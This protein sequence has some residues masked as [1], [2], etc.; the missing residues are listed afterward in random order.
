[1]YQVGG[2]YISRPWLIMMR[3]SVSCTRRVRRWRSCESQ[4]SWTLLCA[5]QVKRFQ[6]RRLMQSRNTVTLECHNKRDLHLE[7]KLES[8]ENPRHLAV[9]SVRRIRTGSQFFES[10]GAHESRELLSGS[11][12]INFRV[13]N[14][15]TSTQR[16]FP[17]FYIP[18]AHSP[19]H[20]QE[21]KKKKPTASHAW[22]NFQKLLLSK[23][24]TRPLVW[25]IC[26]WIFIQGHVVYPIFPASLSRSLA[27]GA[28]DCDS[29]HQSLFNNSVPNMLA[30]KCMS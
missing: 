3:D 26:W 19:A 23:R 6:L 13:F 27:S 10:D 7:C 12:I 16:S 29:Q 24:Q 2:D 8:L 15:S 28:K 21:D 14:N 17:T 1:M 9:A 20:T 11:G 25:F 30:A 5:A 18:L 4:L 22:C